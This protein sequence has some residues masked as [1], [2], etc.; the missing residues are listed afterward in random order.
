MKCFF[1]LR[2]VISLLRPN[3]VK[4]ALNEY[5]G[6]KYKKVVAM[7]LQS[8]ANN[9]P[10]HLFYAILLSTPFAGAVIAEDLLTP[11]LSEP[12]QKEQFF[13]PERF[14]FTD[15]SDSMKSVVQP[16]LSVSHD[17]REDDI[18]LGVKQTSERVHGEV[19]GKLNL[20]GDISL[21]TFAKVPVYKKETVENQ[22]TSEGDSNS[23]L[24]KGAGR[25]SWRSELGVPVKKGV[26][27]NFFYDK[28][29]IGKVDKPGV[30][31]REEKFGTRFIFKF[32]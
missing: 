8:F 28:S 16:H 24:L 2:Q 14:S 32:K 21:T 27:L 10:R 18:G 31:E 9:F 3:P 1:D 20:L 13:D 5:I 30:E 23:Q 4:I 12:L 19:G 15:S 29:T 11:H 22:R 17:T 7:K 25:F 26:D 6:V